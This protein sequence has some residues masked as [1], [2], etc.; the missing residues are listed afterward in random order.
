MSTFHQKW[1]KLLLQRAILSNFIHYN[2]CMRPCNRSL[3]EM[4][5]LHVNNVSHKLLFSFN[6]D[7]K[8][9]MVISRK[10][11]TFTPYSVFKGFFYI[12]KCIENVYNSFDIIFQ[13][14]N[15]DFVLFYLKLFM[16]KCI[17]LLYLQKHLIRNENAEVEQ[18]SQF[19]LP[20]FG[21]SRSLFAI[22]A[23]CLMNFFFVLHFQISQVFYNIFKNF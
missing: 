18:S 9:V 14:F 1:H 23:H 2:G 20:S 7:T 6:L 15:Y 5:Y 11:V 3:L 17:V 13:Y 10:F 8:G 4:L 12:S 19:H 16:R 22:I 21:R